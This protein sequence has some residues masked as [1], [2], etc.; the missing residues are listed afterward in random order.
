MLP[1]FPGMD[2]YL[3]HPTLWP[4]VHNGL[5]AAL[6][7]ALRPTAPSAV[8]RRHWRGVHRP[9]RIRE[10]WSGVQTLR[11][12]LSQQPSPRCNRAPAVPLY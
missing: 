9:S 8:L 10:C 4:G 1:P 2:S 6:Q 3:E 5:I 7:L 11:S 12:S